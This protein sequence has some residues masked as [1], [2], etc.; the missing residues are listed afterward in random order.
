MK[1]AFR[2]EFLNRIDEIVIFDSLTGEQV[3]WIIGLLVAG[4][5]ERLAEREITIALTDAAKNWLAEKGY[6]P[7]YG[8]RPLKREVQRYVEDPLAR[9]IIAGRHSRGDRIT[10]DAAEDGLTF[11]KAETAAKLAS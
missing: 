3:N 1:R 8:A 6:D 2:P 10:V 5:E 11:A 4:V 9:A 7:V